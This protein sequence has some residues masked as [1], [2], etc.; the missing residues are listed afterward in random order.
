[1]SGVGERAAASRHAEETGGGWQGEAT[2]VR[3]RHSVAMITNSDYI[4]RLARF[5]LHGRSD[6][7]FCFAFE[8]DR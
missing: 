8:A 2:T 3:V 6:R 1:M 4:D 5:S 7:A